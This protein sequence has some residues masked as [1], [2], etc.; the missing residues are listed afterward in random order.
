[1]KKG[2]T[3]IPATI[4]IIVGAL[5]VIGVIFLI[6][7]LLQGKYDAAIGMATDKMQGAG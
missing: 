1:M 2:Y 3:G 5:I 4:Y 7:V 6:Y